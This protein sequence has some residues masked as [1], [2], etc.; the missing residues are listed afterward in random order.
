MINLT[1]I[2]SGGV[3]ILAWGS[4]HIFP[5]QGVVKGF[6]GLSPD[7]RQ[8]LLMEWVAEGLTLVFL[9]VLVL[10]L[11]STSGRFS[12]AAILVYRLVAGMLLV[13]AAWT[14]ATGAR[15]AILPIKLCPWVKTACA[16]AIGL[17]SCWR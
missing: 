14:Q 17:G 11:A 7:N 6:G 12:P 10:S 16:A 2:V 15:T 13:M 9:G 4:A 8:I 5:V 1:L 3:L